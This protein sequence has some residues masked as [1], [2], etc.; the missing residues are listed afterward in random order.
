ML[1]KISSIGW[2]LSLSTLYDGHDSLDIWKE[3]SIVHP[4][5]WSTCSVTMSLC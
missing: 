2:S 3:H 4:I 5:I 1:W